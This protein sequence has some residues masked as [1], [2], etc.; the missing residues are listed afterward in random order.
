[1][2]ITKH[3][4]YWFSKYWVIIFVKDLSSVY[5]KLCSKNRCL[6]QFRL[7]SVTASENV[8][9]PPQQQN[10]TFMTWDSNKAPGNRTASNWASEFQSKQ[11]HLVAGGKR[12]TEDGRIVGWFCLYQVSAEQLKR[13]HLTRCDDRK[14]KTWANLFSKLNG[15]RPWAAS[16]YTVFEIGDDSKCAFIKINGGEH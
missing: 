16:N 7:I 15:R 4:H 1:M 6:T 13:A 8:I 12:K 10:Q 3:L 11:Q 14:W 9:K 2:A 5:L